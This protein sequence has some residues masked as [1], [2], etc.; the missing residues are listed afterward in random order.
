[1]RKRLTMAALLTLL[2]LAVV[3]HASVPDMDDPGFA[4]AATHVLTFDHLRVAC[5]RG[6]SLKRID[7]RAVDTWSRSNG[8]DR[9]RAR[10]LELDRIPDQHAILDEARAAIAHEHAQQGAVACA[11]LVALTRRR[12]TQ[13]GVT[14]PEMLAALAPSGTASPTDAPARVPAPATAPAPVAPAS[15]SVPSPRPAQST[16]PAPAGNPPGVSPSALLAS[17]DSYGFDTRAK[18][19]LGGMVALDVVPVVLFRNGEALTDVRGLSFPG[20]IAA[21][22]RAHADEWTRWQR[23]GGKIQLA[24]PKGWEPLA[25]ATTYPRLPA[26]FRLAGEYRS[27]TGTGNVAIGGT[28]SVTVYDVYTFTADG[29]VER[30]GGSG[31]RAEADR[32]S[33][34]TRNANATRLGTYTVSGLT[35]DI[36][37]ADGSRESRIL[38]TDPTD[39]KSAIWLDGESY[40]R[41]SRQPSSLPE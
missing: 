8:I 28:Q 20:G 39:P 37:Y 13:F 18:I 26:G 27:V 24:G 34:V 4:L 7:A 41:R 38:I 14:A 25:F 32:T 6:G 33:A 11:E 31:S 16:P 3:A 10:I 30:Q 19:G 36:R 29:R 5:A 17:I 15:P 21:H 23:S 40:V 35:I 12:E 22:R 1:M 9:I 2:C